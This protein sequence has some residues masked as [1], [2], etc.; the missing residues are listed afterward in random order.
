MGKKG[1]VLMTRQEKSILKFY[2][3]AFIVITI[4]LTCFL[5]GA[6]IDLDKW[7]DAIRKAEGNPNYGIL[8]VPCH[9]ESECRQICKN[10]VFNTLVKYRSTRCRPGEDDVTCLARRYAPVGASNDPQGLNK[11]WEKNVRYFLTH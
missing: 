9:S 4:L 3:S 11:N 6:E 1:R 10:T 2:V 5:A 8:S 7:A